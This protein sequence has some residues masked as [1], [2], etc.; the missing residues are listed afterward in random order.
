MKRC[1]GL[2]L[3]I[4]ILF[5]FLAGCEYFAPKHTHQ[6]NPSYD[7]RSHFQICACGDV[8][9]A[10]EHALEW[11]IDLQPTTTENGFKHLE[12][13]CGFKSEESTPV[14][15]LKNENDRNQVNYPHDE[16]YIEV[17]ENDSELVIAL[18]DFLKHIGSHEA[19]DIPDVT[20]ADKIDQIKNG[21]VQPLLLDFEPQNYYFICAYFDCDEHESEKHTYFCSSSYTW[22]KYE[23]EKAIKD[24]YNGEKIVVSLQV[25]G[26]S[27]VRNILTGENDGFLVESIDVYTPE[28]VDGVNV[29]P[30]REIFAT[31]IYLSRSKSK[32]IYITPIQ[33]RSLDTI[34]C[35][36][37]DN[38]YYIFLRLYNIGV[39]GKRYDYDN[40]WNLGKYSATINEIMITGKYSEAMNGG[41]VK[42]YGLIDITEF[43]NKIVKN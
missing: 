34:D 29:N 24:S 33:T 9:E 13:G 32:T 42:H 27:I 31:Y 23:S 8:I 25:N 7:E 10:A 43:V 22:V 39:D 37:V 4:F 12:C 15:S 5:L 17:L 14:E 41:W 18:I 1:F 3:T 35:V 30:F 11:V 19:T 16:K 40:S 28:F 26:S 6:Y 20:L 36:S 21:N 2:L 38:Q